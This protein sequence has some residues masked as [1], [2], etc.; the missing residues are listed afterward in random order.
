MLSVL[1]DAIRATRVRRAYERAGGICARDAVKEGVGLCYV[2]T[3]FDVC[4]LS[5]ALTQVLSPCGVL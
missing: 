5:F 1:A 3:P 4:G 2:L